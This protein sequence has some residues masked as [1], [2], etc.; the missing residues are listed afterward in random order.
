MLETA[1]ISTTETAHKSVHKQPPQEHRKQRGDHGHLIP[2]APSSSTKYSSE[3][4]G[5]LIHE[6]G[7]G[8]IPNPCGPAECVLYYKSKVTREKKI[9]IFSLKYYKSMATIYK[10]HA[11]CLFGIFIS[12]RKLIGHCHN[13]TVVFAFSVEVEHQFTQLQYVSCTCIQDT[14]FLSG[15]SLALLSLS[16]LQNTCGEKQ[17][18]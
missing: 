18:Q 11:V 17:N 4:P 12:V 1:Y 9:Y 14:L 13:Q 10:S 8:I 16:L 5:H 15:G 2:T 7:S 3:P 6:I